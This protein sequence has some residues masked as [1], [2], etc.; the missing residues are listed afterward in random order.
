MEK[1]LGPVVADREQQPPAATS[2]NPIRQLLTVE[3]R[4]LNPENEMKRIF[5]SRVISSDTRILLTPS[6]I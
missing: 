1:T 5:G 4:H 2:L 3:S 6:K